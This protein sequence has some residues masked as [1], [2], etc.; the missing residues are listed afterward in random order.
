MDMRVSSEMPLFMKP[1][2][3]RQNLSL[4][5]IIAESGRLREIAER[6][7][8]AEDFVGSEQT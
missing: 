4:D 5:Y 2:S 1:S 6:K 3:E 8:K 7:L